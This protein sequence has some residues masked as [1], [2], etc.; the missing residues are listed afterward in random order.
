MIEM[1][2]LLKLSMSG[3]FPG[4]P[5]HDYVVLTGY[6]RDWIWDRFRGRWRDT[7]EDA[8]EARL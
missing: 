2:Y 3:A 4:S 7:P 1:E 6:E 5:D 8:R